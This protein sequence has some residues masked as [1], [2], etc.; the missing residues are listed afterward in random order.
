MAGGRFEENLEAAQA[1]CD[2]GVPLQRTI[3]YQGIL[4]H[5]PEQLLEHDSYLGPPEM[6]TETAVDPDPETHVVVGVAVENELVV[7]IEPGRVQVG[8]CPQEPEPIALLDVLAAEVGVAGG[9]T[10]ERLHGSLVTE[11][12]LD[13]HRD[14]PG[15]GHQRAPEGAVLG[16]MEDGVGGCRGRRVQ[17]AEHEEG[18]DVE[19]L[20][21][22]EPSRWRV[23]LHLEQVADEIVPVA[24]RLFHDPGSFSPRWDLLHTLRPTCAS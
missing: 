5:P 13:G 11:E 19:D 14:E 6:R 9:G 23:C 4:G 22:L 15:V 3:R 12:F 16:E 1:V 10:G 7:A 8:R 2:A 17:T 20:L 18:A 21:V 24:R